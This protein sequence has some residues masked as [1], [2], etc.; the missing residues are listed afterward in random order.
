[1]CLWMIIQGAN[2]FLCLV[3]TVKMCLLCLTNKA[4]K[5]YGENAIGKPYSIKCSCMSVYFVSGAKQ[6]NAPKCYWHASTLWLLLLLLSFVLLSK[7]G[8]SPLYASHIS[9][10]IISI[11]FFW[12]LFVCSPLR[13]EYEDKKKTKKWYDSNSRDELLFETTWA[14]AN[15]DWKEWIKRI[16]SGDR[17]YN[18]LFN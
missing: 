5:C 14:A 9:R 6:M 17:A 8:P 12:F 18:K 4:E 2:N 7:N 15:V 3:L 11:F 10:V 13:V 16:L 1:M